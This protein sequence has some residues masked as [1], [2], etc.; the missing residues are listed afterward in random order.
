MDAGKLSMSVGEIIREMI[1]DKGFKQY[2][3]ARKI[4]MDAKIFNAMLNNRKI[5]R[6]EDLILICKAIECSPNQLLG[7]EEVQKGE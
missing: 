6:A 5:I 1:R 3:I 7:Y 2:V 4:G